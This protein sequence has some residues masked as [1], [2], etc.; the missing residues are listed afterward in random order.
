MASRYQ[1]APCT[2]WK[3]RSIAARCLFRLLC[4]STRAKALTNSWR[5]AN[6][7]RS[8]DPLLHGKPAVAGGLWNCVHC[9]ECANRCPKGI[10]AAD[11]IAGLRGMVMAKGMTEGV[12]PAHAKSF[13]TDLVEDSG[14]LNEVRLA[15]RTEGIS[16]IARAGM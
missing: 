5:A 11:D 13:Y 7:S 10:S 16:T 8:K 4:R 15:L 2:L 14:R 9:Q 1:A 6:D 12:G 3:K